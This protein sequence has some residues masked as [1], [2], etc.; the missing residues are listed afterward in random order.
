MEPKKNPKY[1]LDNKRGMFFNIGLIVAI[2]FVIT[3]F[4]WKFY[5][6][7]VVVQEES[8]SQ[9]AEELIP[10]TEQPPP[11]PPK[12]KAVATEFIE[13]LEE[14]EIEI[15]DIDI[16]IDQ[17]EMETYQPPVITEP[18]LE[19]EVTDQPFLIVEDMPEPKGG[20][21]AFYAYV[22]DELKYPRSALNLGVE[23]K[24]FVRFVVDERGKI[25]RIEVVKGVGAGCDEEAIRVVSNAPDWKPGKQRGK[26][27]KV[28]III[29]IVFKIH[30][31]GS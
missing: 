19:E 21:E 6:K 1:S 22:A 17:E 14:E 24:V 27:V 9:V 25:T 15:P 30:D 10:V 20:Y 13:V 5:D 28:Q 12:P 18:E 29:P 3:A 7:V 4:E 2:L 16:V 31:R 11:E 26:P 8:A 23:G